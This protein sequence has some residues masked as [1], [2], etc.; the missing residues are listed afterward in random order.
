MQYL[1]Y[2]MQLNLHEII[3]HIASKKYLNKIHSFIY[4]K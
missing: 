2:I 1:N 4:T 3:E